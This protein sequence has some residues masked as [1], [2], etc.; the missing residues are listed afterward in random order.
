[1]NFY[2]MVSVNTFS[3]NTWIVFILFQCTSLNRFD[4]H[5]D[6]LQLRVRIITI[7]IIIY[8]EQFKFL[9]AQFVLLL[10][11]SVRCQLVCMETLVIKCDYCGLACYPF[12]ARRKTYY[13]YTNSIN[14][15]IANIL[16][17]VFTIFHFT[18]LPVIY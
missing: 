14:Q 17:I 12:L 2:F 11:A 18:R 9:G 7:F 5:Y 13:V 16:M 1:M 3:F 8:R 15:Y 6:S 4:N 10:A